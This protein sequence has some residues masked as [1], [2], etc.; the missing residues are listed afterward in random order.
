MLKRLATLLVLALLLTQAAPGL[1][2]VGR[3]LY[4]GSLKDNGDLLISEMISVL[5]TERTGTTIKIRPFDTQAQLYQALKATK[6]EDRVDLMTE[7]T[8]DALT[9][10]KLPPG[11]SADQDFLTAKAYYEKNL[12]TIW[13]NPF[14]YSKEKAKP[15]VSAPLI[16]RDVLTNFPL[17][18]RVLNKLSGAINDQD[19]QELLTAVNKGGNPKEVAKDFL[20]KHKLI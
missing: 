17:L 5:V 6:E 8:A 15:S 19:Y 20:K 18:P 2:C 11:P 7:N 4:L 1:A 14:G 10:A 16:R 9:F 3:T 13:L 12:D